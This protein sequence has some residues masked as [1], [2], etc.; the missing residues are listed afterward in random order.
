M[1]LRC[2]SRLH[3]RLSEVDGQPALEIVCRSAFCGKREGMV[4]LHFFNPLTGELLVTK[5]YK[6]PATGK[7]NHGLGYRVAVRNA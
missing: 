6:E 7:E 5:R 3:A 1:D 4:V 2:A